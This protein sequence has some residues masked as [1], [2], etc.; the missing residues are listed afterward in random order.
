[1]F[2]NHYDITVHNATGASVSV[3]LRL[4]IAAQLELKKKYNEDTRTTLFEAAKDDEKMIEILTKAL[5]WSGNTNALKSGED[6]IESLIDDGDFGIVAR[7]R[8]MIELGG[9]SGIFSNKEKD[10]ILGKV[11]K[12]EDD[13]LHEVESEETDEKN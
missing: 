3:A 8:L 6:L 13:M 1:M 7:Q 4:P 10:M 9:V 11:D 5:N 12:M 2:T